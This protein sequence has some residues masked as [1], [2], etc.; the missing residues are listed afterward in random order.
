MI[1][2]MNDEEFDLGE[3]CKITIKKHETGTRD[4]CLNCDGEEQMTFSYGGKTSKPAEK[5]VDKV[6]DKDFTLFDKMI[7]EIE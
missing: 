6:V 3:G 5:V 7:D 2:N 4:F 1:K